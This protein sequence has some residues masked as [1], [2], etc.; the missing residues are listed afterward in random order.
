[1]SQ[2]QQAK[3]DRKLYIGNLPTGITNQQLMENLNQTLVSLKANLQVR[4]EL[5]L[6]WRADYEHLD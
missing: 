6:A 2:V 4:F 5:Y 1:M 3:A